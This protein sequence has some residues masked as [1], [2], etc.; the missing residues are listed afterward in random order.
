[1]EWLNYHHLLYFW[2]V[3]RLGSIARASDELRLTPSTISTQIRLLEEAFGESLFKRVGRH[4]EL[5]EAGRLVFRYADEIFELGRMLTDA[6]RSH[7]DGHRSTLHIGVSE[8]VPKMILHRLLEPA[9]LLSPQVHI[10]CTQHRTEHLL[11]ELA[12]Q[13]FD[14]VL[15]DELFEP[16]DQGRASHHLLG[17][18]GVAFF[19][20]RK[21]SRRHSLGFPGS[22]E[23]APMVL[24]THNVVLRRV[25]DEWFERVGVRPAVVAEFGGSA[26]LQAFGESGAGLFAGYDVIESELLRASEMEVVGRVPEVRVRFHTISVRRRTAQPAEAAIADAARHTVFSGAAM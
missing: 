7:A 26:L 16:H 15:V 18:T 10:V 9:L 21:L 2:T 12:H 23:G 20:T 6:V 22:L 8:S 13:T 1:M 19:G 3:A 11:A 4:L 14:L 5:S 25:L 17:E 24:P